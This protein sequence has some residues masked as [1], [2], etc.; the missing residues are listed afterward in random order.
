M[1]FKDLAKHTLHDVRVKPQSCC[2]ER[3][4]C[5]RVQTLQMFWPKCVAHIDF[6]N[7]S[8]LG[9]YPALGSL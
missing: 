9:H 3:L 1:S 2:C 8:H 4:V 5:F 7:Y 6:S